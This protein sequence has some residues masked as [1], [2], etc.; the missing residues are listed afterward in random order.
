MS[1]FNSFSFPDV[2]TLVL[3]TPYIF[4][5]IVVRTY[6]Y[7]INKPIS[8]F[9]KAYLQQ[10]SLSK[11]RTATLFWYPLLAYETCE[12]LTRVLLIIASKILPTIGR[13]SG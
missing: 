8:V 2:I 11:F 4:Q 3:S 12:K 13:S 10:M 9:S 6:I 1:P 7:F 5:I